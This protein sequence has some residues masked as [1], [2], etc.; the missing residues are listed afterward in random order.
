MQQKFTMPYGLQSPPIKEV[1]QWKMRT[2][3]QKKRAAVADDDFVLSVHT[4]RAEDLRRDEDFI[5]WLGHATFLIQLDGIRILTDPVFGKVPMTPRLVPAPID[6]AELEVD[7]ILISHG[8]YDHL[9]LSSLSRLDVYDKQTPLIVPLGLASYLKKGANVTELGWEDSIV[10]DS[11][12]ITVLPA[13]HWHRRGV[14]DFNRALW[15]SF[16]IEGNGRTIYFAGD[17]ALDGHFEEIA[18][19]YP[20]VDIA[21]M[22]IGAY[23]P[24]E[25]MRTNHMN[26]QEAVQAAETLGARMMIPYHYGTFKLSDEPIGEPHSWITRLAG[27]REMDIRVVEVG[28]VVDIPN[29]TDREG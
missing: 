2:L 10:V 13:S 17:S 20:A 8:H 27:E 26:P 15:C 24:P 21:L 14:R 6:P 12:D 23:D 29:G 5:V 18:R 19:R 3:F 25:V 28:E 1:L 9:D 11:L 7:V 4:L 22:P 16:A